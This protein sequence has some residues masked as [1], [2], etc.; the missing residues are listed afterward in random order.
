MDGMLSL[1]S[2]KPDSAG[3]QWI[4]VFQQRGVWHL[5]SEMVSRWVARNPV[6][7]GMLSS[8][9]PAGGNVMEL[10]CGPGRHA[11]GAA[12]LGYRVLGFDIE[13]HIVLQARINAR[14]ALPEADITFQAGDMFDLSAIAP[15]RNFDVITHGGIL[16]H[17]DS[18][19]AIRAALR[20]QLERAPMVVFD[21]PV[22]SPKNRALFERDDI[23]RQVWT[24][25]Q[26]LND[27]LAGLNIVEARTDLHP[28]LNMTDDLV[29][30]L[31]A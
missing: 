16:E 8:L 12:S 21:I 24:P 1:A 25:E 22:D 3:D 7:F 6:F 14:A 17:L 26:W 15:H 13:P 23:F 19:A 20:L 28:E 31:R 10:G 2:R 5:T 30:A 9:V 27:V 4:S 11:L 18:A 29:V